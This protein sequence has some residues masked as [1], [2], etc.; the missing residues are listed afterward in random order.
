MGDRE[1][2]PVGEDLGGVH[3][4][5]EYRKRETYEA[6]AFIGG[7][8]VPRVVLDLSKQNLKD[9][10]VMNAAGYLYAPLLDKYNMAD[11]SVD[12]VYLADELPSFAMPGNL[13][14]LYNYATWRKLTDKTQCHPLFS[15]QE[16]IAAEERSPSMNLVHVTN[17]DI[18]T[19]D[20]G[21]IPLDKTLVFVLETS[22]AHGMADQRAF[23]FKME[24][25][26]LDVPVVVKRSYTPP[27]LPKGEEIL[28]III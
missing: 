6:N 10:S 17:A 1:V 25:L 2:L 3:S 22:E 4:P 9:P 20:F 19:E 8:L 21:S 7:H 24:E 14:Q 11:Q 13:K 15:L 26:G 12:F 27:S 18:E 16:Y 23:F 5:Y 28:M